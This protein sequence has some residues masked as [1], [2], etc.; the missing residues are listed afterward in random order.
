MLIQVEPVIQCVEAIRPQSPDPGQVI[1]LTPQGTPFAS[2]WWNS[3]APP[4]DS[5]SSVAVTKDSTNGFIIDIL[6]PTELSVGDYVLNGGEV[7]A[8]VVV[9]ATI[10]MIPGVLETN[11]AVGRFVPRGT[12]SSS[13]L[14]TRDLESFAATRSGGPA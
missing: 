3:L 14:N 4:G 7:A 5:F 1:L 9:D 2:P 10:R 13:S 12:E 11:K 8:M 6:R